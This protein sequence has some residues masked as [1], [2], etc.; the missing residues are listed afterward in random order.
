MRNVNKKKWGILSLVVGIILSI[1]TI[2]AAAEW[3]IIMYP[4]SKTTIRAKRSVKSKVKGQLNA[5]QPVKA[6]FLRDSWYAVFK[7]TETRRSEARALGYVL[8]SRLQGPGYNAPGAPSHEEKSS[9]DVPLK[10]TEMESLLVEVKN[11]T[12]KIVE[13]GKECIFIEFD[14][15]YTP[16][17]STIQGEAPRIVLGV[18]NVSS[19]RKEWAVI[20]VGGKLIRQIRSSMNPQTHVAR[21]VLDME[22]SKDYYVNP[23]FYEKENTYSLE[24]FEEKKIQTP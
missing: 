20:Y 17:I 14:R 21:I 5:G 9:G 18:T 7:V 23:V 4:R 12:F 2:S 8:A 3:G 6:D 16:A 1:F 19:L 13:D 10:K 24:V 11:I 22:T 15:F